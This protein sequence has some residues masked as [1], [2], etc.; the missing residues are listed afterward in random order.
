MTFDTRLRSRTTRMRLDAGDE[1]EQYLEDG[2]NLLEVKAG[3]AIPLWLVEFLS[4]E[5]LFKIHF[6]KV[7]VAYERLC[8]QQHE[9][10]VAKPEPLWGAVPV[11]ALS[12][13]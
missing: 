8:A 3:G 10:R 6:S 11:P 7:G 13:A 12:F 2:L 9:A 4:G 5:G 1:G